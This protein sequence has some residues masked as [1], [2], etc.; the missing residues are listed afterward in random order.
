MGHA[1]TP[2][3]LPEVTDEAADS[4]KW[5]PALGAGLFAVAVVL[6]LLATRF[7]GDDA[8]HEAPPAPLEQAGEAH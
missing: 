6:I 7:D 2:P 1:N 4:P 5:L 3:Q 8:V